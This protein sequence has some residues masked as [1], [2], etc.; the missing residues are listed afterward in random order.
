MTDSTATSEQL[1]APVPRVAY[2]TLA[3]AQ[4]AA[5]LGTDPVGGLSSVEAAR[6]LAEHGPN[7][8]RETKATPPWK[9]LLR[10]FEDFMIWVLMGAA[11]LAGLQ[12]EW[13]DTAAIVTIL[14]L[15]AVLGFAQEFRAEQ[16]LA[17]LKELAAPTAHVIRDGAEASIQ[18]SELVPGDVVVLEAGDQIPADGRL[19]EAAALRIIESALTGESEPVHKSTAPVADPNA[20]LGDRVGMVFAGTAVAVGRGRVI[21][22]STG[23]DTE[24]GKI[25]DLLADQEDEATP[26]QKELQRVGKRIALIVLAIAAIIF[27]EQFATVFVH[28]GDTFAE[29]LTDPEIRAGFTAALLI[30]VSLAVA[31]IPEGLPAVVT[32][33]LSLGVRRMAEH[34]AIVRR[35]TAV[36][37]LGSTTFICSDKT[38]TLTRNEMAVRRAVVGFDRIAIE[39]DWGVE[40]AQ[41]APHPAD[42]ALLLEMAAA[43][44]DARPNPAGGF[45]GDPTETALLEVASHLAPGHLKPR[46]T[47]EV[48]FD[49]ERKR[50]TTV[51]DREG[52]RIA[53]V[54][55]GADVVLALCTRALIRGE[56]V[57]LD[58]AGREELRGSN[59]E[60]ASSGYRT[61]AFATRA[62]SPDEPAEDEN[63]ERDL[64]YVGILGLVDPPRVE[65]AT[66]LAE[67]KRAGI[68]VA[69]VT[70]DHALTARAIAIQIGLLDEDAPATCVVTGTELAGM[71]D[72]ELCARAEDVRVY[73]RVNPEDKIRIVSALKEDGEVVAMTG[74]GVNDAPALKRADIGIA[75][76]NIGTDVAREAADMV[77]ADDNFATIVEAVGEG[78]TVFDNLQKVILFLLS[79]N[80]S[81]VLVVFATA[82]FVAFFPEHGLLAL[83]PLQ[84][85]WI[86][87][88]TD[89]PPALA[90]GVDP[91]DPT[92]MDR[93]PRDSKEP[94]LSGPRM[95]EVIWQGAV[96]T[97]FALGATFLAGPLLGSS[98]GAE[99]TML[100]TILVLSQKL[101]AFNYRSARG[102][103][104]SVQ[105]LKN[106]WL[107]VAFVATVALQIT[108]VH[109]EFMQK[110]F[111]TTALTGQE[112][113]LVVVAAFASLLIMDLVKLSIEGRLAAREA[114]SRAA[115]AR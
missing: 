50:M 3:V 79:C 87:L 72:E 114:A 97:V 57:A 51:H 23:A 29:A 74:D 77:L 89:G 85:L 93:M 58:D 36:E 90:L 35:L 37:T 9:L 21:I 95:S 101:H 13:I 42:L 53:F 59:E 52:E 71:S 73:A 69:M 102:T 107:N 76:G 18:A 40:P 112:W 75:M 38:G 94:I 47:S 27:A 48:P 62:L 80:M 4:V 33:A 5:D 41:M 106:R 11:V 39:A 68:K 113:A 103:V 22:T 6:R 115:N 8:L 15:N 92:V 49:S 19:E 63:I 46:R 45:L 14:V 44:N 99:N 16:A 61:L 78:R 1:A 96:M 104:F 86:N 70:G 65:V 20:S 56:V 31:A 84:L 34:N 2:H 43:N 110:L 28:S 24:V 10:Q 81:E 111:K 64:T 55:G 109:S 66:A 82:I 54:K 98:D 7:Q 32:I 91:A 26:L 83:L 25:A 30:S 60:L 88:V 105:S 67:C 17:A 12:G 100:F 108:V